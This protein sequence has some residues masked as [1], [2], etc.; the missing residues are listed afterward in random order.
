MEIFIMHQ[1][2]VDRAYRAA[3]AHN[4]RLLAY[5]NVF[6]VGAGSRTVGGRKTD[7]AS[8]VVLVE[9]KLPRSALRDEDIL[10]REIQTPDGRIPVDVVERGVPFLCVDTKTYRPLEGGCQIAAAGGIGTLGGIMY[11]R[12][13]ASTVLLTCA[14]VLAPWSTGGAVPVNSG[15]GQPFSAQGIGSTKRLAPWFAALPNVGANWTAVFDAGIVSL[16]PWVDAHFRIV[17]VGKHPHAPLPPAIGREVVKRGRSSDL[18]RGTIEEIR[19]DTIA[20]D[21]QTGMRVRIGAEGA[22][23][24]TIRA[25]QNFA[26]FAIA[27]DSGSLV[28]DADGAGTRGLLFASLGDISWAMSIGPVMEALE[29]ETPLTGLFDAAFREALLR[30]QAT[31]VLGE[32]QTER[33]DRRGSWLLEK[34]GSRY[35]GTETEGKVA[36]ALKSTF[37]D[38]AID[39]AEAHALDADFA[40]L[41]DLAVGDWLVQPTLFDLLEYQ[42]PDDFDARLGRALDR[43]R[44]LNPEATGYEWI[45]CAF[46]DC[47]GTRMRDVLARNAPKPQAARPARTARATS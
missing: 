22:P 16:D 9:R 18:T 36:G 11:D 44:E 39:F 19:V 45:P 26:A 47:G 13:D 31:G 10:P 7:E 20:T 34:F 1:S 2:D 4:K 30:R 43:F 25:S 14:H 46:K 8:I 15:V 35:L 24:F 23:V 41:L 28:V 17:E 33:S 37:K 5:P 40:G 27:G 12:R 6:S 21:M 38:L 42:L 32:I 3:E 29:L